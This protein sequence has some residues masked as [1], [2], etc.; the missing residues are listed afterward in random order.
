MAK[1]VTCPPCGEAFRA[2]NDQDLVQMVQAHAKSEH[3]TDL[4]AE[5]IL[6]SAREV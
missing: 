6:E 1:E 4:T 3:D 2:D 5:H